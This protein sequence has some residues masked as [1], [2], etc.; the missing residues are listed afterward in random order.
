MFIA[1]SVNRVLATAIKTIFY[2]STRT[3]SAEVLD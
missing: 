2:L 1:L 3:L